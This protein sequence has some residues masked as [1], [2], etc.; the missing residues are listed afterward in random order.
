MR[1]SEEIEKIFLFYKE[2]VNQTK[3]AGILKIPRGTVK[4][5]YHKFSIGNTIR[6]K[7][8]IESFLCS[9]EK[10]K[11]YSYIF[12]LYLGD[13]H[14]IQ[15]K[16]C[17]NGNKV[18]KFRIFQDAKYKNLIDL[19]IKKLEFLFGT[20]VSIV[21]KI[22]CAEIVTYKSNL[23]VLFPQHG[24]GKKHLRLI[25]LADWQKEIVRKYPK[26]FIKGLIH[27]DG[28]RYLSNN[29]VKYEL[30]NYSTD[31]L[32]YFEWACGLINVDTRRH[33]NGKA[34]ILRNKKD[35]DIFETF[36]GPKS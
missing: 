33:S 2:G 12:G 16:T 11:V 34:T 5:Y 28:C 4:D 29:I 31:I 7:P 14:I 27:S 1:T 19:C 24:P 25:E 15:T 18:Y 22:N 10:Q 9:D 36:I 23:T 8:T 35:V 17:K 3:A 26:E 6:A 13:G 20:K 30:K 21:K 32:G